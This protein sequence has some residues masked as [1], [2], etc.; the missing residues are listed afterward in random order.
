MNRSADEK[1][2]DR[3]S[4]SN[5]GVLFNNLSNFPH[6]HPHPLVVAEGGLISWLST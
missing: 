2:P 3:L 6:K 5:P 1:T 4:P